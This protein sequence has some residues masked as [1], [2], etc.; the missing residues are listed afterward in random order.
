MALLDGTP[1]QMLRD[2]ETRKVQKTYTKERESC[3]K[4][5][6]K[7]IKKRQTKLVGLIAK[8]DDKN[9]V[10]TMKAINNELTKLKDDIKLL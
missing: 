6:I 2:V 5:I 8:E 9:Y 7:L 4:E 1:E 10:F 3:K